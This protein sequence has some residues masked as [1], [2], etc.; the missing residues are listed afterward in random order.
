MKPRVVRFGASGGGPSPGD[1][2]YARNARA[3]AAGSDRSGPIKFDQLGRPSIE[4]TRKVEYAPDGADV[5][6]VRA[7]L[8]AVIQ[9]LI[10]AGLMES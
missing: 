8:N 1:P 9:A 10:D 6:T 5:E 2:R 7:R 4:P 3:Q